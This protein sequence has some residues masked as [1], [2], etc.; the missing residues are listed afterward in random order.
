VPSSSSPRERILEAARELF[1]AQGVQATGVDALSA[2]A[3]VSKRTLY[4][5]FGSKDELVAEH[6]RRFA[7]PGS[8]P[9]EDVLSDEALPGGERVLAAFD[10]LA[11]GGA[12]SDWR[13]CP[14]S[15]PALELA[16]PAHPARAV[17]AEHKR[18]FRGRVAGALAEAGVAEPEL[19]AAHVALLWDGALVHAVIERSP[20]PVHA[21]RALVERLLRDAGA[22]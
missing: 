18:R 6:L 9:A 22:A 3:G 1:Y 5:E 13:G 10:R 16:D 12:A 2:R 21:A 17:S 11:D 14:V 19:L 15:G 20:E 8:V 4:R 7:R